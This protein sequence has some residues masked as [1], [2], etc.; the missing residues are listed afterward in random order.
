M[1]ARR[2]QTRAYPPVPPVPR[3]GMGG[4]PRDG[5][6]LGIY[7][8]L[9]DKQPELVG[10]LLEVPRNSRGTIFFDSCGGSAYVGL[11]L[12]SIIRMRGI[13]ADGVVA[14]ECSSAALM[15]FAACKRRFVTSHSTLLFHPIRWQ[16]DEDVRFEE[17]VEW[18]RHFK[19]LEEDMDRLLCRMFDCSQEL[20]TE[21]TRPGRFVT[22]PEMVEAGMAKLVDLFQGDVWSQ[23]DG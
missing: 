11:G 1:N 10:R 12:A 7:G 8:D 14:G 23:M 20:I 9:T 2:K 6:E 19:V 22:G 4:Y 21:W 3:P 17:A 18:A 13:E 16:S 5:W 15:P